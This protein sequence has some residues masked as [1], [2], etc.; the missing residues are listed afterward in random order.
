MLDRDMAPRKR[1]S[2]S[3]SGK[4]PPAPVKEYVKNAVKIPCLPG[5]YIPHVA[6]FLKA[7]LFHQQRAKNKRIYHDFSTIRLQPSGVFAPS[8]REG[9]SEEHCTNA[10]F[11]LYRANKTIPH[12]PMFFERTPFFNNSEQ[13]TPAY[14]TIF[15]LSAPSPHHGAR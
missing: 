7:P 12:L 15:L 9:I 2:P 14:T 11:L 10:L 4:T 1:P 5:K 3:L 8:P 6:V 13:K